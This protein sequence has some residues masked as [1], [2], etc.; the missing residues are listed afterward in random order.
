MAKGE[1]NYN[2]ETFARWLGALGFV[3]VVLFQESV[4]G[5]AW[6]SVSFW[7]SFCVG[8]DRLLYFFE[9]F[10]VVYTCI[11]FVDVLGLLQLTCA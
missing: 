11:C 7:F 4:C 3:C 1:V 2:P 5:A 9:F 6:R 10:R 8:R